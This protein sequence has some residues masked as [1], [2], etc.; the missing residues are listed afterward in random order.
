MTHAEFIDF[1]II[2]G[3]DYCPYIPKIGGLTAFSLIRKHKSIEEI[4]SNCSYSF[5]D[6]L[7][8]SVAREIFSTFNYPVPEEFVISGIKKAPLTD[9]LCL[10]GLRIVIFS[11]I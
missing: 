8:H 11:D 10:M 1:C 7:E 9:F 2:S 4:M 3:C 5:P 6:D